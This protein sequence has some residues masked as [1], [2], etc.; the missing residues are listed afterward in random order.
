MTQNSSMY[1]LMGINPENENETII[2]VYTEAW[3]TREQVVVQGEYRLACWGGSNL[4]T[5]E[6]YIVFTPPGKVPHY[7]IKQE[8]LYKVFL[9]A[10]HIHFC[11]TGEIEYCPNNIFDAYKILWPDYGMQ[12]IIPKFK[13]LA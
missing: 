12:Q 7:S 4:L 3:N 8:N 10:A 5:A 13:T 11:M 1:A 6:P 9:L 2:D